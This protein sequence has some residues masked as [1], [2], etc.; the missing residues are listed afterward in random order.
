MAAAPA[1]LSGPEAT[2]LAAI[3]LGYVR[4]IT[5]LR[6]RIVVLEE[7]IAE[8]LAEN[9]DGAIFTSLPRSG[10]VRAATLLAPR[11]RRRR[12]GPGTDRASPATSPSS[13]GR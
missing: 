7:R 5:A 13:P 8:Q 2:A 11:C 4:A 1:G 9:P 6:E 10:T 12:L 3:T